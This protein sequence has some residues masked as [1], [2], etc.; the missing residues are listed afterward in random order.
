LA[1]FLSVKQTKETPMSSPTFVATFADGEVTR[2]T[3]YCE[4]GKLDLGRGGR[5]SRSA[6]LS[7][8]GKAAPAMTAGHFETPPRDGAAA[9]VLKTFTADELAEVKD[10]TS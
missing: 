7:R 10:L 3:T 6:Y 8:K 9:V 5:L 1:A 2:M 4:D